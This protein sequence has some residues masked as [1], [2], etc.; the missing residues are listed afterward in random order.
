MQLRGTNSVFTV[1]EESSSQN[2]VQPQTS[3]GRKDVMHQHLQPNHQNKMLQN[4]KY[5]SLCCSCMFVNIKFLSQWGV[6]V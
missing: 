1:L 5:V 4:H 3:C 6:I 2:K